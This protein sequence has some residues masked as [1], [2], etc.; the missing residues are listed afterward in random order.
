LLLL[1]GHVILL[2]GHGHEPGMFR[3][4]FFG[5]SLQSPVSS[6]HDSS[7]VYT[8][9][10]ITRKSWGLWWRHTYFTDV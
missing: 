9:Q 3:Q 8:F 1:P 7:M 10:G 6:P 5:V 4:I 2:P